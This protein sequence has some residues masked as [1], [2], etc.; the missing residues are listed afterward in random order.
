MR[1]W[2]WLLC[3]GALLPAPGGCAEEEPPTSG[4]L[5]GDCAPGKY[6]RLVMCPNEVLTA[7]SRMKTWPYDGMLKRV[8]AEAAKPLATPTAT[9]DKSVEEQ[10]ARLAK[11]AALVAILEQDKAM[12]Q[13]AIDA[14]SR[15]QATWE[16]GWGLGATDLFI[17]IVGHL[18]EALEG[19]DLVMGGGFVTAVQK[20]KMEKALGDVAARVYEM[21]V[22]GP[23]RMLV[24][25]TQNNYNTKLSTALGLAAL[26]LDNHPQRDAWLRFAATESNRFYGDGVTDKNGYLSEEGVCKE[27]PGY[28]N[29]GGKA[30]MPFA[31]LYQY[32]VGKGV[33][34]INDCSL[35]TAGCVEEHLILDGIL[36]SKLL[37]KAYEWMVRIQMPDGQRPSIDEG[38]ATDSPAGG[39]LWH[40]INGNKML[41]W[42][43][44][45][46]HK[47]DDVYTTSW[48][49][50]YIARVDF[51]QAPKMVDIGKTQLFA[52][53]G[54]V[55]FRNSWEQDAVYAAVLGEGG[56]MRSQVHNHA[57]VTS[58]QMFAFG[59]MLALDTGYFEPPG[60]DSYKSRAKTVGPEA[61]NLILVD[62]QGAPSPSLAAAGDVDAKMQGSFDTDGLDYTEVLAQYQGVSFTRS[63]LFASERY[64][65]VADA[66]KASA[67]HKYS[68]RLHGHG[69]GSSIRK[70]YEV[71]QFT[72]GSDN[73]VWSRSKA[74]MML[75][76][77]STHGK[78]ALQSGT[79]PHEWKS[80]WEGYHS[81]VDGNISSTTAK[82]NMAFLAVVFPQKAGVSFPAITVQE[83]ADGLACITVVGQGF[84]D[85]MASGAGEKTLNLSMTGFASIRT[86]A[87]F[88]W[89][90][91]SPDNSV[92]QAF[93][94]GGKE[95]F[96]GNKAIIQNTKGEAT[97]VFQKG[98]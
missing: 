62:G 14:I 89:I 85:V 15:L 1:C 66:L 72:L 97:A 65:V 11:Y 24:V 69:G 52:K 48:A 60:E 12:A 47:G 82:P 58:F 9:Y 32:M 55:I 74:K 6:P 67:A 34:F 78:P 81:Y 77:D 91:L 80:S 94:K 40:Y 68:W 27:P 19:Y 46:A 73:A 51:S 57:D 13:K 35:S 17:R 93:I 20:A 56:M 95:L 43:H 25:F 98:K 31:I 96:Y 61:H 87:A 63:V 33:T 16:F 86:D 4:L 18:Q 3:A 8:K 49:G 10:N 41:L 5:P 54:Q 70:N 42:D 30:A 28:F 79:F 44:V 36:H 21:W 84:K 76:L 71:G 39:A 23:G 90:S 7:R 22:T 37:E 2:L 45:F 75:V 38:R 92:A 83:A 29:F 50:Y 64:L 53:S 59:E 26:M 88:F